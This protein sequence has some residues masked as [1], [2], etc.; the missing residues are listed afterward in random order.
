MC[1]ILV[2]KSI[3]VNSQKVYRIDLLKNHLAGWMPE[4]KQFA[5]KF[6]L[7]LFARVLAG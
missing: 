7:P 6:F 4:R 3:R 1:L 5:E 2:P